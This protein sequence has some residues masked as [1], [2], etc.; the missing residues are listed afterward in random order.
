MPQPD[1][2]SP[3]ID[4][5]IQ[6]YREAW[7]RVLD[8]QIAIA[9]APERYRRR[10]RLAEVRRAIEREMRDLDAT[11]EQ[12]IK[13]QLPRAYA[14]GAVVALQS[15]P[16]AT[17]FTWTRPHIQAVQRLA[18][19]LYT[20]LLRA[21]AQVDEST[22]TL[23]RAIARDR[24]LAKAIE[25]K[26]AKQAGREMARLLTSKGIYAVRYANGA[27]H[28]LATYSEMA[29]R[30]VS[31]TAYNEGS[32]NAPE[33]QGVKFWEVFDGTGCGWEYHSSPRAAN[34][35]VV[36]IDE[37]RTYPLGHPNCR[38]GFGPRPD[39]TS[40][41]GARRAARELAD[42]RPQGGNTQ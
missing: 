3:I 20:D 26:T 36:S 37:A 30:T 38:R 42:A 10:N 21:T 24:L 9:L 4:P 28:S 33:E 31:G 16:S 12:W 27:R 32:L 15:V 23:I 29:I 1:V 25:G 7:Q 40:K 39:V 35:M 18:N 5:L 17:E 34:G 19:S 8:E 11:A 22:K 6:A 2:L 41:A 14:T 13:S